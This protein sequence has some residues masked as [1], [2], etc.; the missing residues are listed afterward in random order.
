MQI[1]ITFEASKP[2]TGFV[3]PSPPHPPEA[4]V[5]WL[6]L[7]TILTGLVEGEMGR[8]LGP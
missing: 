1:E 7:L 3:T 6:D 8:E 5:G 2:P 4:F